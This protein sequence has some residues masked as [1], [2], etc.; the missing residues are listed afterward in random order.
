MSDTMIDI[1]SADDALSISKL[2][3]EG[4]SGKYPMPC[5]PE[6]IAANILDEKEIVSVIRQGGDVVGCASV[7]INKEHSGA[8]IG[9]VSVSNRAKGFALGGQLVRKSIERARFLGIDIIYGRARNAA[10]YRVSKSISDLTGYLPGAHFVEDRELWLFFVHTFSQGKEKHITPEK[11]EIYQLPWMRDV[12]ARMGL[13]SEVGD[14]PEEVFCPWGLGEKIQIEGS[15]SA[16]DRSL[17]IT[18][19][20]QLDQMPEYYQAVVLIDKVEHIRHLQ[21]LGYSM[22]AYLPGWFE[23]GGKRY[24]CVL[25]NKPLRPYVEKCTKFLRYVQEIQSGMWKESTF[26]DRRK[27]A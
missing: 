10:T 21:E 23:K 19:M 12:R 7:K 11:S 25:L 18:S 9:R 24:D 2:L 13:C 4:Y 3:Q 6:L 1:A 8:E 27:Y 14:Y 16:S 17:T 20:N 26:V 22:T 15:Y 5:E